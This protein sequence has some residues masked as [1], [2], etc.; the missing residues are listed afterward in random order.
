MTFV[1]CRW[2]L[3]C[4][5][6]SWQY[7][8]GKPV[9]IPFERCHVCNDHAF[10]GWAAELSIWV[11]PR[12]KLCQTFSANVKQLILLLLLTL[13]LSFW[14][15]RCWQSGGWLASDCQHLWTRPCYSDQLV[16]APRICMPRLTDLERAHATRQ[17]QAGLLQNHVAALFG[18]SPSIWIIN[19]GNKYRSGNTMCKKTMFLGIALYTWTLE[20]KS[21]W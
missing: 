21:G 10:A 13:V 4:N 5:N 11:P 18:V 9:Y 6:A 17:L 7:T 19:S 20:Y 2:F 1:F 8:I 14:H 15:P 3:G 12:K 16:S